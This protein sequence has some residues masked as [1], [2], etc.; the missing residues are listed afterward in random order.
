[1]IHILDEILLEPEHIPDVLRELEQVYLSRSAERGL[2]LLQRWISPPVAIPGQPNR[3]WLLWQVP[4]VWGYYGM[5]ASAGPEVSA[6]WTAVEGVSLQRQP[7]VLGDA[8][9]FAPGAEAS[10]HVA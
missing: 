10:E 1:M 8:C 9:Q 4:D 6:F 3:L 5:R 2:T 7:H